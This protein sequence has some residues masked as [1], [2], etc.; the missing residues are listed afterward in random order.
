MYIHQFSLITKP[1]STGFITKT[2]GPYIRR[3]FKVYKYIKTIKFKVSKT[4]NLLRKF[5]SS[6]PR[7]SLT[8]IYTSFVRLHLDYG[9]VIFDKSYNTSFQQRLESLQD[10]VPFAIIGAIKGSST[11][12][13]YKE[14]WLEYL[15]NTQCFRKLCL[16]YKIVKKQ[17]TKY[18]FHFIPSNSNSY[19]TRN[20]QNLVISQF[21]ERNNF[22]LNSFFSWH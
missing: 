5:K 6:L 10:K 7:S 19:K 3:I 12:K 13:L 16:F 11:E 4:I 22:F 1:S 15:E 14:L 17:P 20:R 8:T 18:L 2:L 9:D 21:K